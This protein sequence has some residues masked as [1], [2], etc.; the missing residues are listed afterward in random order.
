MSSVVAFEPLVGSL[1]KLGVVGVLRVITKFNNLLL[2]L[3]VLSSFDQ[4]QFYYILKRLLS[5]LTFQF[6]FK[7]VNGLSHDFPFFL[8]FVLF[9]FEFVIKLSLSRGT[10]FSWFKLIYLQ[11]VN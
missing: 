3:Q 5:S 1:L 11:Q 9:K 10:Y 7:P 2:L 4:H 6:S 8:L